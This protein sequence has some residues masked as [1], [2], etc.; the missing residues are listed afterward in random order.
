MKNLFLFLS[1]AGIWLLVACGEG[2]VVT[3]ADPIAQRALDIEI[4]EDY[5]LENGYEVDEV[6]TTESGVRYI[7]LDEGDGVE[8]IDESDFVDFEYTGRLTTGELFDSSLEDVAM[9]DTIVFNEFRN[10]TPL[11]ISYS[12][13]GWPIQGRF[14]NGFSDGISA[15]FS[16]LH[17]GAH[18]LIVL[19][20]D[21]GYGAVPQTGT[22]GVET[23]PANSVLTFELFPVAIEKQ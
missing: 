7:I 8:A 20:S 13:T 9:T 6:D 5:L 19:P 3:I 16:G 18:V 15:T 17:V 23:I 22:G 14:I 2:N 21:I 10:Y 1:A 4:I 12:S 11:T